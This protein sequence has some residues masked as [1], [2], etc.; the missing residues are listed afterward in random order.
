[1]AR[2]HAPRSSQRLPTSVPVPPP[3]VAII[4][5]KP[6]RTTPTSAT[7]PEMPAV[8]LPNPPL[9]APA[10]I[11]FNADDRDEQDRPTMVS[12]P[13]GT[14][15]DRDRI[16]LLRL[17]GV[18]AGSLIT[19]S[20]ASCTLGRHTSNDV[21][22]TDAGVSRFHARV[23]W[24]GNAHAI[25]DLASSNGTFVRGNRVV[26][27]VLADGDLV[28]IG[29]SACFRY[30][31]ADVLHE[32]LL[33]QLYESSTRDALSGVWNRRHFEDCLRSELAYARRHETDLA[34]LLFDLDHFKRVNDTLGHAA[35]DAVIR[36]V[37]QT[38]LRQLRAE[39]LL[40]RYG[41]EEFIVVMR[42]TSARHAARAAERIR[43]A[44]AANPCSFE[45]R[46]IRV[47]VSIG[48]AALSDCPEP[49][50]AHLVA[51]VDE[52]LYEAKHKGRNRVVGPPDAEDE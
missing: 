2:T 18:Q 28:Q 50:G 21:Q 23:S 26:R 46:Q 14:D 36:H 37:A 42:S 22:L 16:L 11:D 41:G 17:D 52:R 15:A 13:P 9:P 1:M 30:T 34:V 4:P 12:A 48:C 27:E 25:E 3:R 20:H 24:I 49:S 29:P 45:G 31:V 39:D 32:R 33:R 38:A 8:R 19:L 43:A 40:A 6:D 44:I 10:R 51:L 5:P 47:T 35:G 7:R